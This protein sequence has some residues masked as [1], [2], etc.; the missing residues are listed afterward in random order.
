MGKKTELVFKDTK[1][2][3]IKK[4]S[5]TFLRAVNHLGLNDGVIDR[6]DRIVF[7]SVRHTFVSNLVSN[8][9]NL[10]VVSQLLGH[11]DVTMAARYSHLGAGSLKA[12]VQ[13]MENARKQKPRAN[14]VP[15]E[16]NKEL[17]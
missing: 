7:H 8:G 5:K 10:Y 15:L 9:A 4:I 1:G 14:V 6:R 3:P 11:T 12:A 13:R 2:D 17:V 16:A